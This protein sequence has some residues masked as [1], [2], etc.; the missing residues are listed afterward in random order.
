MKHRGAI[1]FVVAAIGLLIA[2]PSHGEG[3]SIRWGYEGSE[4]PAHWGELTSDFATCKTGRRQSPIDF[5][6]VDL[7]P[8]DPAN[9]AGVD[10]AY[11]PAA[12]IIFN[13]GHTVELV[14]DNGSVIAVDGK[15]YQLLQMHYHTPSEHRIEGKAY[16]LEAHFVH[17]ARDGSFAVV[18][19]LFDIGAEDAAL[20][21]ILRHLHQRST[22]AIRYA[23]PAVDLRAILPAVP[24]YYRY[25]GSFTTPPCTEGVRWFVVK[26]AST[27]S[28]SQI[29]TLHAAMG[30]N[31]RPVQPLNGRVP[32]K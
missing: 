2:P 6:P 27:A 23:G 1:V 12:T 29:D 15:R 4:G 10:I 18:G 3:D 7:A 26:D 30:A 24:A 16:P 8:A 32:T 31:A 13:E 19:Q 17:K 20:A 28:K 5:V 21:G 14:V 22:K 11:R 9:A 25:R